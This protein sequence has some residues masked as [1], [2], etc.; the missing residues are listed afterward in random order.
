M[1]L[2]NKKRN[3]IFS[4]T[5]LFLSFVFLAVALFPLISRA[6]IQ[7]NFCLIPLQDGTCP[8]TYQGGQYQGGYINTPG[9]SYDLNS[10]MG[11]YDPN[12]D[13]GGQDPNSINKYDPNSKINKYDA[14]SNMGSYDANS[15]VGSYDSNY[16]GKSSS[17]SISCPAVTNYNTI[18]PLIRYTTCIIQVYLIPIAITLSVVLFS[19][20]SASFILNLGNEEARAKAKK[21]LIWGILVLFVMVSV[22]GLVELLTN[23]F[24]FKTVIPQLQ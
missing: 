11:S 8:P 12:A 21:Y 14:N 6:Q 22:W 13:V 20:G 17:I 1:K 24:G 4:I 15:E 10:N 18:M 16:S 3:K 5:A 9:T 23:F 19:Y 2:Q 7:I